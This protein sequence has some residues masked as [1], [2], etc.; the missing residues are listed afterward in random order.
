MTMQSDEKRINNEE[1]KQSLREM[2]ATNMCNNS[3]N[4]EK[5]NRSKKESK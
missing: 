4:N 5:R 2:C 3:C 1:N